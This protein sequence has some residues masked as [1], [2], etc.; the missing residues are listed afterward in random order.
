LTDRSWQLAEEKADLCQ[1]PTTCC[2]L[3]LWNLEV[4]ES[5]KKSIKWEEQSYPGRARTST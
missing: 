4:I 1:L 2:Q 5:N 3:N